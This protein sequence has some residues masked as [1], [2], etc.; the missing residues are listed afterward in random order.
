MKNYNAFENNSRS[1]ES[2]SINKGWEVNNGR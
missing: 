2:D 1:D